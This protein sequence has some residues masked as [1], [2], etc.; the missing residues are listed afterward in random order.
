MTYA[1]VTSHLFGVCTEDGS[2][3]HFVLPGTH[4]KKGARTLLSSRV[5]LSLGFGS[6]DRIIARTYTHLPTGRTYALLD[7]G[8]DYTWSEMQPTTASALTGTVSRVRITAA[9]AKTGEHN[10][11]VSLFGDDLPPGQG[12]NHEC[13]VGCS[14]S[15]SC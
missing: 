2:I 1:I 13:L 8:I 6:P 5:M 10:F 12:N 4:Y 9:L 11:D 3:D 15:D 7:S 14:L